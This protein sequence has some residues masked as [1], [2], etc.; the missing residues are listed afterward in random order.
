MIPL[1]YPSSS[2]ADDV[3]ELDVL[4]L[5]TSLVGNS[6]IQKSHENSIDKSLRNFISVVNIKILFKRFSILIEYF[7]SRVT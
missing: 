6:P 1:L 3:H 5:V 4:R 2:R 7:S